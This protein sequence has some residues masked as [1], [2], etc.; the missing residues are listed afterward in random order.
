MY[1]KVK[2]SS[3]QTEE[4]KIKQ[5][6]EIFNNLGGKLG[7]YDC[8]ICKNK[9][10]VYKAVQTELFGRK[11][12]E[13]VSNECECMKIRKEVRRIRQSGLSGL[14]SKN[15]FDNYITREDWQNYVKSSAK[16]YAYNP[17]G[18]FYIGG[19]PGCGKT[20]ICSAIVGYLL[21][22]GRAAKYMLWQDDI[23]TL[24]QVINDYSSYD[25]LIDGYKKAE[26]LYID[27]FFKTRNKESVTSADVNATFK[28]INYR[29]NEGLRTIIS[30]E[31]S[32]HEIADIDE[33]LG[34]R[35]I[36]MCGEKAIYIKADEFKNYRYKLK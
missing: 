36:E 14:I 4:D 15:T 23:T 18:W 28:I 22:S 12:W 7:D 25:R 11:T 3:E 35:I 2:K 34:S 26:I 19:Q 17:D 31:L 24:K 30:S 9:G 6:T 33:A 16:R 10:L 13:V 1:T 20:H 32:L 27:D 21:K 5:E 8:P 29:Y